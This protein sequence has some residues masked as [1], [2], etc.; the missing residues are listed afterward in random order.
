MCEANSAFEANRF[1]LE[2]AGRTF[3][4]GIR[5]RRASYE[6]TRAG[7]TRKLDNEIAREGSIDRSGEIYACEPSV[8]DKW[9]M[10]Q[11]SDHQVDRLVC[12]AVRRVAADEGYMKK[13][14]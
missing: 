1:P 9:E 2:Q 13:L 3:S 10:A 11:A 14:A 6:W 4:D 7:G 8:S 12:E 5:N